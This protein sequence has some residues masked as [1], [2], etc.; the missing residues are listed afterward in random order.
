MSDLTKPP[1]PLKKTNFCSL[2]KI[3]ANTSFDNFDDIFDHPGTNTKPRIEKMV[4]LQSVLVDFPDLEKQLNLVMNTFLSEHK[5]PSGEKQPSQ[6]ILA[7][8]GSGEMNGDELVLNT[9][10]SLTNLLSG[11]HSNLITIC[12]DE[13]ILNEIFEK[14]S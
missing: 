10:K 2:A 14:V 4:S 6:G 9:L 8:N 5:L 13:K 7:D 12:C 1:T 11:F 3:K